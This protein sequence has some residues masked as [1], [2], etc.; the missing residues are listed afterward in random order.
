MFNWV[1]INKENTCY[2][3][4]KEMGKDGDTL[5]TK[6][7]DTMG[8][9]PYMNGGLTCSTVDKEDTQ[10]YYS[11]CP[12]CDKWNEWVKKDNETFEFFNNPEYNDIN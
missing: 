6:D 11:N 9:D 1:K 3:C 4:K 12:H 8:D 7:M 5:Q 10:N 2:F